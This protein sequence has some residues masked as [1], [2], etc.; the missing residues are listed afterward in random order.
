M[1]WQERVDFTTESH[2]ALNRLLDTREE[3]PADAHETY[4]TANGENYRIRIE[5]IPSPAS[6]RP[7]VGADGDNSERER[8]MCSR[9]ERLFC[10][11]ETYCPHCGSP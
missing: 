8:V 4:F 9:C 5:K 1:N 3:H 2:D 7:C 10:A 6:P 11:N